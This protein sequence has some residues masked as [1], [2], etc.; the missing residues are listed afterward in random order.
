MRLSPL[1]RLVYISR[2]NYDFERPELQKLLYN[3]R[4]SNDQYHI[5]GLLVYLNQN[6]LQVLEGPQKDVI[7]L[8]KN[9][10]KDPRHHDVEVL[11]KGTAESR[12]FPD[13]AMA[14]GQMSSSQ[15]KSFTGHS[16]LESLYNLSS[17][18]TRHEVTDLVRCFINTESFE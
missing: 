8:Y 16:S 6:F 13:W 7:Q 15:L 17:S 2:A 11:V 14:H 3:S 12:L 1:Y 4:V 18:S 10:S 5:T 9:I